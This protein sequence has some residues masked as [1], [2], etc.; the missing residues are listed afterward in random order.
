MVHRPEDTPRMIAAAR[1]EAPG[2]V[3]NLL[4]SYRH[5]L[6][7][8]ARS[9]LTSAL[10]PK[11]DRSDLVQETLLK[12]HENFATFRGTTEGELVA[13]L[14]QILA[15]NLATLV[16]RFNTEARDLDREQSFEELLNRSSNLAS[17]IASSGTT[18]SAA[19]ERRD[20]CLV[21]AEAMSELSD[22]HREVI[23]LRN[24]EELSWADIAVRMRRS[25]DAVRMLWIRA[26]KRLRPQIEKRL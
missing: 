3:S 21:L 25:P 10:A 6:R 11:T 14:R 9:C 23:A 17:L 20:M 8:L 4:E 19:V 18:P 7:F 1:R 2:A 24:L 26:L 22:L 16:R 15:Q 12:A 5:Y 13:W